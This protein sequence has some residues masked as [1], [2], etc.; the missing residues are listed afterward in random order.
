MLH[1][2]I[3]LGMFATVT[4]PLIVGW[5]LGHLFSKIVA[6]VGKRKKYYVLAS[7]IIILV[8]GL[9]LWVTAV[10]A[11]QKDPCFFFLPVSIFI[12]ETGAFIPDKYLAVAS[13]QLFYP[14]MAIIYFMWGWL[15]ID[16]LNKIRDATLL[17]WNT[18]IFSWLIAIIFVGSVLFL[19]SAAT[20]F[21]LQGFR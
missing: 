15:G 18:K 3:G 21:M 6:I 17:R 12:L 11:N 16:S 20:E 14:L 10:C 7:A 19:T 9:A 1:F 5:A 4:V 8:V 2:L 13:Q